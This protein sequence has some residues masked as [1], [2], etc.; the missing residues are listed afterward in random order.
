MSESPV[1]AWLTSA[2]L[3]LWLEIEE[4]RLSIEWDSYAHTIAIPLGTILIAVSSI[5]KRIGDY[6]SALNRNSK[7]V[8][9]DT[10]YYTVEMIKASMAKR[11]LAPTTYQLSRNQA[12]ATIWALSSFRTLIFAFSLIFTYNIVT[13][14]RTYTFMY[15]DSAPNSPLVT[16]RVTS[17][18]MWLP[19][20]NR[21]LAAFQPTQH[22]EYWQLLLWTPDLFS[23]YMWS[24][25]NPVNLFITS[26][27]ISTLNVFAL[28]AGILVS[29]YTIFRMFLALIRD[30]QVIYQETSAEYDLKF[31]RPKLNISKKDVVVDATEGPYMSTVLMDDEPYTFQKSKVFTTHDIKGKPVVQYGSEVRAEA[32]IVSEAHPS[33]GKAPMNNWSQIRLD[34]DQLRLQNQRLEKRLIQFSDI[35][36]GDGLDDIE[37]DYDDDLDLGRAW[38]TSATPYVP[39]RGPPIFPDTSTPHLSMP[40]NS[41]SRSISPFKNN[42]FD[43]NRLHPMNRSP[44][45]VKTNP[46]PFGRRANKAYQ[47]HELRAS[48]PVHVPGLHSSAPPLPTRSPTRSPIRSGSR[49]PFKSPS[50]PMW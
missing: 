2:P 7:N 8:L 28:V 26:L 6:Y 27:S 43:Q 22:N 17:K 4:L 20:A 25:F 29:F 14:S 23:I 16:R 49:L 24:V 1:L 30:K 46:P 40:S 35:Y 38:F 10:D 48:E 39:S 21:L 37:Y 15:R 11:K 31:V 9:F 42:R 33:V 41:R 18:L 36:D 3:D 12:S 32:N 5:C 47:R 45:P 44:S 19:W 13:C 50:R 34:N